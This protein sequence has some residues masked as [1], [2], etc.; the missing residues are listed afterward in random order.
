VLSVLLCSFDEQFSATKLK[1]ATNNKL[2]KQQKSQPTAEN[3]KT[4]NKRERG[5]GVGFGGPPR[6]PMP[7][8]AQMPSGM[9][10]GSDM[11]VYSSW[12]PGH[13]LS[14]NK[15]DT[16]SRNE[17]G[18][19]K[20]LSVQSLEDESNG[21]FLEFVE[22]LLPSFERECSF[23][24]DPP[25]AVVELLLES[26]ILNYCAELLRN[27]SLEDATKRRDVYQS[28]ISFLRTLGAHYATATRAI[29]NDRP[30]RVDKV[31]LLTLFFI[32]HPG[33]SI[34]TTSSLY[35]CLTNLS[36]QSELVL[37]GAER[38]EKEFRTHDGQ[39]L[40]LL[41]RQISDLQQY[42]LA[43]L[44]DMGNAESTKKVAEIPA[45]I[46]LPDKEVMKT[47]KFVS[48]AKELRSTAPGRFRRLITEITTLK[49]G[50]PPGIFVRYAESRPDVQKVIII[51]PVGTP[52]E[53]GLFEFDVF[54]GQ[55]FPNK[56]PQVHFKTTGGG[57]VCFNPNLYPDGK[58]CLSLLGTW[59]GKCHVGHAVLENITNI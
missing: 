29:Y 28:L 51:G 3:K 54:C 1:E 35:K 19:A 14:G 23:D 25:V 7:A 31:N 44:G 5:G 45:L 52:Y 48:K 57:R 2:E 55:G 30:W 12:G 37:Q 9:G 56:P 22:G 58:V 43:N 6:R 50:L 42:L 36:T 41:C 10:Y 26:K 46:D 18:K 27:D 13:T 24:F 40:L 39:N 20:A 47:H 15:F 17:D 21:L 16:K 33:P 11:G 4:S 38:N 34:E 8:L 32:T 49:T 53:N 59:Q